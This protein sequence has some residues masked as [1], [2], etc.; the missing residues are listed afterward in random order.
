MLTQTRSGSAYPHGSDSSSARLMPS[1][2]DTPRREWEI[3]GETRKN[4]GRMLTSGDRETESSC[5]AAI[6]PVAMRGEGAAMLTAR[7]VFGGV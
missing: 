3:E 5:P 2:A 6:P 1:N 4:R 7:R